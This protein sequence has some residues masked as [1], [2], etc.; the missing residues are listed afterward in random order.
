MSSMGIYSIVGIFLIWYICLMEAVS[1]YKCLCDATRLRILN[2]LRQGPLCV[3]DLQAILQEPQVKMSKHLGYLKQ[4][5]LIEC[6]RQG[7]WNVY[8]LTKKPHSLLAQNLKCLQDLQGEEPVFRK[9]LRRL[10]A[11][12][13][14]AAC[15]TRN[16]L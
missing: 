4:H 13:L 5:G 1:V 11:T 7:N 6:K 8:R 2:L 10:K 9:D 16:K 15:G 14:S 3:C 12:S